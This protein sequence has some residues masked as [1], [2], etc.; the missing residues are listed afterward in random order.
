MDIFGIKKEKYYTTEEVAQAL[1]ISKQTLIRYEK[2]KL[3][4][5]ARRNP[6]NNWRV[7]TRDDLEK[8]LRIMG[9]KTNIKG[10]G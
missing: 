8:L 6:F 7:Y 2:K 3:L 4:P 9:I 5:K 10:R 1:G